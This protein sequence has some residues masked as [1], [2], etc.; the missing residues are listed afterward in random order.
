MTDL[1]LAKDP[2]LRVFARPQAKPVRTRLILP[3]DPGKVESAAIALF[4]W[5]AKP[6]FF[7]LIGYFLGLRL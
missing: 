4:K 1:K 7:F 6:I 3:S 2:D 5:S